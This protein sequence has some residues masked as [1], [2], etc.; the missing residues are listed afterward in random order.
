MKRMDWD[1]DGH[2]A[3]EDAKGEPDRVAQRRAALADQKR[4]N[5]LA[6]KRAS[7]RMHA[8]DIDF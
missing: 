6:A 3:D 8:T 7:R 1:I 2:Q 4:L 5:D